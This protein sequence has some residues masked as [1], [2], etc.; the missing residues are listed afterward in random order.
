VSNLTE[1]LPT[2]L[3]IA[4]STALAV[5]TTIVAFGPRSIEEAR[6]GW[7]ALFPRTRAEA[8][9]EIARIEVMRRDPENAN[10]FFLVRF[11]VMVVQE[12]VG[13]MLAGLFAAIAFTKNVPDRIVQAP[14]AL[15]GLWLA[16]ICLI[17]YRRI[18]TFE[19]WRA[20][21]LARTGG[22]LHESAGGQA[23]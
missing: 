22:V 19:G 2:L 15:A 6:A 7:R 12:S 1:L 20:A 14:F 16:V 23:G 17:A 9:R 13:Q 11:L 18:S 4:I 10:M 3:A 8:E 21:L 5:A